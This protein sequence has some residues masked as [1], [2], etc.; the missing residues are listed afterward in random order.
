MVVVLGACGGESS[1]SSGT[2][3]SSSATKSGSSEGESG[4]A[5]DSVLIERTGGIAGVQDTLRVTEAGQAKVTTKDG[6]I[7][8]KVPPGM[9]DRLRDLDLSAIDAAPT[10]DNPMADGFE[11][12][13]QIGDEK[14]AGAEGDSGPRADLV[15]AAAAVLAVCTQQVPGAY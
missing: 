3:P 10:P 15:D 14:A 11:Y 1:S 4:T 8:C 2:S 5:S 13:V 6:S 12:T 7:P 9:L